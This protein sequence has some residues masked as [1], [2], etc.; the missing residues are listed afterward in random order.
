MGRQSI[1]GARTNAVGES[2]RRVKSNAQTRSR[3]KNARR[4]SFDGA[5]AGG[6]G[7]REGDIGDDRAQQDGAGF[8]Q[9]YGGVVRSHRRRLLLVKTAFPL[10]GN[11]LLRKSCLWMFGMFKKFF[12]IM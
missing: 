1:V 10:T 7:V 6:A 8:A 4:G 11:F 2:L 9:A 3:L 5:H 12:R